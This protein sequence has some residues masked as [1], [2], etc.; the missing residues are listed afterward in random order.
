MQTMIHITDVKVIHTGIF[1]SLVQEFET[2]R[3]PRLIRLK[4]KV[5]SGEAINDVDLA[6]LS[7]E[8]KDACLTKHMIFNY[9]ELNGFCL[10]MVHLCKDICDVAIENEAKKLLFM[11]DFSGDFPLK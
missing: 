1:Q 4:D 2:H 8:I 11:R 10:L 3:L 6:F 5:D 7:Q 9:P